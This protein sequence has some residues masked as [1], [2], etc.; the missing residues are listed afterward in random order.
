[1]SSTPQVTQGA[2]VADLVLTALRRYPERTAFANDEAT[3][4]YRQLGEYIGR[5]AQHLDALG[6]Q[7]GDVVAQLGV[8]RF[9]VFAIAVAVYLRGLRSVMLHAQAS[10]ADHAFILGDC[11]ARVVVVDEHHRARGEALRQRCSEVPV[12]HVLGDIPGFAPWAPAVAAYPALPLLSLR[13]WGDAETVVRIAYTGGTTGQPKGVLLSNRALATNAVIDLAA[14]D[15]PADMRYLCVAPISH[16]GGSIVVPTLMRGGCITLLRGFSVPGF[17]DAI[18]RHRCNV[19]WLVPTMLYALLDSG[20]AHEVDWSRFHTLIY[21][22]AP[23]SPTRLAQAL[24][25]MGPV[26]LQSYGQTEAPNS[27]LILGRQ[28]HVGLIAAQLACGR[29]AQPADAG[30]PAGRPG[31]R[32]A[33]W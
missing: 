10:E 13:P 25:L 2:T 14:K 22:A 15:F 8:N 3:L 21:S 30:A 7:P 4:S 5:V 17:V 16:G 24:A 23:A 19:T 20:R 12:W 28:D 1:M 9:E 6:L 32:G 11:A 27:L 18:Q 26:L 33:R 29:P 31:P